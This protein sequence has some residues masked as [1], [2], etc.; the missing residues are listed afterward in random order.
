MT[1]YDFKPAQEIAR[2]FKGGSL[3]DRRYY[4]PA[5]IDSVRM[6]DE[7]WRLN[8]DITI[9]ELESKDIKTRIGAEKELP[10]ETMPFYFKCLVNL[11]YVSTLDNPDEYLHIQ[12]E[13]GL[14]SLY[15][16]IKEKIKEIS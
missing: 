11:E 1:Y 5:G 6:G 13:A 12:L 3:N 9:F 8:T 7:V 2:I 16:L 10:T 15:E 14:F 4:L